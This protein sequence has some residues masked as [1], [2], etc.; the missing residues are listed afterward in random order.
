MCIFAVLQFCFD[1][2][3]DSN[4]SLFNYRVHLINVW[5]CQV[6]WEGAVWELAHVFF[7]FIVIKNILFGVLPVKA[8]K[9]K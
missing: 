6:M 9:I 1:D 3:S 4:V 8:S 2:F 7:Y 5:H